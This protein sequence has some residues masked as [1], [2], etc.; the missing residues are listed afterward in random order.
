M[1]RKRPKLESLPAGSAVSTPASSSGSV[2]GGITTTGAF[3]IPR[4]ATGTSAGRVGSIG[5]T[6]N[7]SSFSSP[8]S[9]SPL[10]HSSALPSQQKSAGS[11]TSSPVPSITHYRDGLVKTTQEQQLE[12]F[13]SLSAPPGPDTDS[14]TLPRIHSTTS[15]S[16]HIQQQLSYSRHQPPLP[17]GSSTYSRSSGL[18]QIQQVH[19]MHRPGEEMGNTSALSMPP[20]DDSRGNRTL[21]LPAPAPAHGNS[22]G[23]FDQRS[24]HHHLSPS[25]SPRQ[26][27]YPQLPG[28][29]QLVHSSSYPHPSSRVPTPQ[30]GNNGSSESSGTTPV[31]GPGSNPNPRHLSL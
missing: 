31:A 11:P 2:G 22:T 27:N 19:S 12:S 3:N 24:P 7:T 9:Q 21:P 13:T 15:Q 26:H 14:I 29:T 16:P 17:S 18:Q 25:R 23:Y 6:T 1:E 30:P 8:S 28:P 10:T 20:L 5:S 4:S